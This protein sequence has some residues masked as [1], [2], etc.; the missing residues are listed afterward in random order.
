MTSLPLDFELRIIHLIANTIGISTKPIGNYTTLTAV[1]RLYVASLF[2][3]MCVSTT[4]SLRFWITTFSINAEKLTNI[5]ITSV[6]LLSWNCFTI[7]IYWDWK[8]TLKKHKDLLTEASGQSGVVYYKNQLYLFTLSIAFITVVIIMGFFLQIILLTTT[9]LL[10]DFHI[11]DFIRLL[12]FNQIASSCMI[13][14]HAYM[15]ISVALCFTTF[16]II[17]LTDK[18]EFKFL[19][20][21]LSKEANLDIKVLTEYFHKHFKLVGAVSQANEMFTYFLSLQLTLAVPFLVLLIY[22]FWTSLTFNEA[23]WLWPSAI[24][25]ILFVLLST[26]LPASLHSEVTYNWLLY[27]AQCIFY[28]HFLGIQNS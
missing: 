11:F 12:F 21:Q 3:A 20:E 8:D 13:F 5:I 15:L 23:L 26:I 6:L 25:T 19:N 9:S 4:L 22:A 28:K 7:F 14:V 1:R 10:E 2:I 18:L 16:A 27:D 17:C 24:A